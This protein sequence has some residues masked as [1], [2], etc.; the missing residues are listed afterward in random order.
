M[1]THEY[2][3][4]KYI[5]RASTLMLK[6]E[7]FG[8]QSTSTER[9]M[10]ATGTITSVTTATRYGRARIHLHLHLK[11]RQSGFKRDDNAAI[12]EIMFEPVNNRLS[13]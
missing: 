3:G 5:R 7:S 6:E 4:W 13:L 1:A 12:E 8:T 11:M 10:Q 2:K 9:R